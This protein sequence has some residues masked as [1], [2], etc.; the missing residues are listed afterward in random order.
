MN[1]ELYLIDSTLRDGEQRADVAFTHGQR[2]TIALML[3][4]LGIAE[5]EVGTPAAGRDE[6][7]SIR[8]IVSLGLD[9]RLTGWCRALSMDLEAAESANLR[10]VHFSLP[11]SRILLS[12]LGRDRSWVFGQLSQLLAN[13]LNRFDFVSVGL[14]DASRTDTRFLVDLACSAAIHGANRVRIAD[15]VGVW[16]PLRTW[17][18]V[19]RV[20]EAVPDILLGFHGHNDL[21]MATANALA[22]LQ[23]GA[24]CVD[25]TVNG[26]GERAGNA[27][28]EEVAMALKVILKEN[29]GLRTKKLAELCDFVASASG[30]PIAAHKPIVGKQVFRHESGIHV[31]AMQKDRRSYEPFAPSEVGQSDS[32]TVLGKHSGR[33]ALHQAFAESG[34]ELNTSQADRLLDAVRQRSSELGRS[35]TPIEVLRLYET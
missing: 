35:L 10:S 8:R 31:R 20:R 29:I 17:A 7:E 19:G 25:V 6:I 14:Q 34:I 24:D 33:A 22:A 15:T 16:D 13:A 12:T 32:V 18:V 26:L 2:E 21:G 30:I 1:N 3:N 9:C 23:A 11:V 4:S 28:L 27:A 5:I